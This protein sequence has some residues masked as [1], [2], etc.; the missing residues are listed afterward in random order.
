MSWIGAVCL[1]LLLHQKPDAGADL[2]GPGDLSLWEPRDGARM[3][4]WTLEKGTL[5]VKP[6]KGWL[7]TKKTYGDLEIELEWKLPADGNSGVFLRVPD[8][9]ST[10]SPS[11]RGAEI[12]ILDDESPKHK[13]KLKDWQY[14]GSIYT[15]AAAKPGL[16]K[17]GEWN[18][19]RIRCQGTT[20]AV[21][22][23]GQLSCQT[24]TD[25]GPLAGRPLW[26]AIGL[27]NHGSACQF[28]NLR[29]RELQNEEWW[30]SLTGTRRVLEAKR[31]GKLAPE[32][33][34]AKMSLKIEA[35]RLVLVDGDHQ[36]SG[37]VRRDPN[38]PPSVWRLEFPHGSKTKSIPIRFTQ[39]SGG[40]ELVFSKD[41]QQPPASGAPEKPG[42]V[43]LL[44]GPV[45][46]P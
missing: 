33:A 30:K 27:Q 43:R 42:W 44:L 36:E 10:D 21:F 40:L 46:K 18:H 45:Q 9:S 39:R 29:I 32:S 15:A 19:Y 28:R 7:G 2:L 8:G 16:V 3:E 6:G 35:D 38:D 14:C 31:S 12:Q 34:L 4:D 22:V 1:S 26:G 41:E 25:A 13:G 20:I 24:D 23:N 37:T 5:S 17:Q 11:K